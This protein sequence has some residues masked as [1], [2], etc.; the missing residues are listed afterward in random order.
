MRKNR[1]RSDS[2]SMS[3]PTLSGRRKRHSLM[4]GTTATF[5]V[6]ELKL[7]WQEPKEGR[8]GS[9]WKLSADKVFSNTSQAGSGVR[10]SEQE[11]AALLRKKT[12]SSRMRVDIGKTERE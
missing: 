9:K 3:I 10:S 1:D 6:M 5:L 7:T 11:Q 8:V 12:S 2:M 4:Q